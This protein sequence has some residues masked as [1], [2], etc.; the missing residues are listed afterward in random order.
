MR[1]CAFIETE[2]S[3]SATRGAV[4][5]YVSKQARRHGHI[6]SCAEDDICVR[7]IL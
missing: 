3:L 5:V 2:L 6:A 7:I 4:A 1:G